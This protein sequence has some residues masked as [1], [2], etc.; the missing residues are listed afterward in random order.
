MLVP[1]GS[2][3]P[4]R[5]R[6]QSSDPAPEQRSARS[7]LR[8]LPRGNRPFDH[9]EQRV[10]LR[11]SK[12]LPLRRCRRAASLEFGQQVCPLK[13]HLARR[14]RDRLQRGFHPNDLGPV[15]AVPARLG[16]IGDCA[17]VGGNRV[18]RRRVV[19]ETFQLRMSDVSARPPRQDGPSQQ[20][21]TPARCQRLAVEIARMHRPQSHDE[22]ANN[23]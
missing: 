5:I 1:A 18:Q 8:P 6:H 13:R 23:V 2:S 20:R 3:A 7:R 14:H 11:Q 4:A 12:L 22:Q 10:Q 16:L 17:Q 21:F 9:R 19:A 15:E